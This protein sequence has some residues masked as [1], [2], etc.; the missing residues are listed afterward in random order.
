[1]DTKEN[2]ILEKMYMN[3]KEA[4]QM[5][6]DMGIKC[7][8]PTMITWCRKHKIGHQVGKEGGGKWIIDIKKFINFLHGETE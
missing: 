4:V 2:E 7:T 5:A 3:T 6:A 1:M 8:M